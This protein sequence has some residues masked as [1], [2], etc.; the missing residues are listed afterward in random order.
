MLGISKLIE[1][2][3][4]KDIIKTLESCLIRGILRSKMVLLKK[5]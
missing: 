2:L 3:T 4:K 1:G 5:L